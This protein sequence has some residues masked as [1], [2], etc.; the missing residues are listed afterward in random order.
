LDHR[1]NSATWRAGNAGLYLL[2]GGFKEAPLAVAP[3]PGIS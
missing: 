1:L 2:D 3:A